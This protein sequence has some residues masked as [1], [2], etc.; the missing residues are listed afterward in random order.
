MITDA[1]GQLAV[2]VNRYLRLWREL[3]EANERI[4]DLEDE[5]MQLRTALAISEKTA[6]EETTGG[7]LVPSP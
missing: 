4:A 6:E 2:P 1:R 3:G 7:A 5:L